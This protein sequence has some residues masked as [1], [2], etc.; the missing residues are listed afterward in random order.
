MNLQYIANS[1][2][3]TEGRKGEKTANMLKTQKEFLAHEHLS[4][5]I[6]RINGH[7]SKDVISSKVQHFVTSGIIQRGSF[8][9][10]LDEN[11]NFFSTQTVN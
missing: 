11:L 7:Q 8:C 4:L 5:L 2:L 1:T 6:K 9:W 10:I 3:D